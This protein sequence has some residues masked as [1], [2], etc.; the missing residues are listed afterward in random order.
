MSEKLLETMNNAVME[1]NSKL[2][3]FFLISKVYQIS[4]ILQQF[5]QNSGKKNK[6]ILL[7]LLL[8]VKSGKNL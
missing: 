8:K 6:K 2:K 7:K 4:Y 3:V 5:L 1:K